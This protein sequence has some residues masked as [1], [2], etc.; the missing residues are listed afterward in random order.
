MGR[1]GTA[2]EGTRIGCSPQ[3]GYYDLFLTYKTIQIHHEQVELSLLPSILPALDSEQIPNHEPCI[4][5]VVDPFSHPFLIRWIILQFEKKTEGSQLDDQEQRTIKGSIY[6]ADLGAVV[7]KWIAA[8]ITG[9]KPTITHHQRM[10]CFFARIVLYFDCEEEVAGEKTKF[11][12]TTH[13]A[14]SSPWSPTHGSHL[15]R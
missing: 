1:V 12:F 2:G 6:H 15:F 7:M 4:G 9:L 13:R 8:P 11:T 5:R 3:A 10:Y 14:G